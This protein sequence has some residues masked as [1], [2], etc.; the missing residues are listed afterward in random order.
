MRYAMMLVF[1]MAVT[2]L[3]ACGSTED[4]APEPDRETVF[5]PLVESLE[6]AEQVE[7]LALEQKRRM[8]DA[9]RQIE[10]GDEDPE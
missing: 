1:A 2:G 10:G 8:D 4:D 6:K 9:L 5:D 3:A 7:D